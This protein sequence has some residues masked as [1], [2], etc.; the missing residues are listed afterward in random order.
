MLL[1]DIRTVDISQSLRCGTRN[2]ITNIHRGRHRY[3]AGWPSRWASAHILV[4][5]VLFLFLFVSQISRELLNGFARNSQR[6]MCLV[7]R[8]DEFECQ[9]QRGQKHALHSCHPRHRT[10]GMRS[11]QT[12]CSSNGW[13]HL[14]AAGGDFWGFRAYV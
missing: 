1:H 5:F 6:K 10:N 14:V 2:G 11:L 8:S 3:L 4:C 7:C 12:A 13:H 9:G